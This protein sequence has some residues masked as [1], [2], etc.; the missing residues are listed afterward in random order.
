[1]SQT[2][3]SILNGTH[4]VLIVRLLGREGNWTLPS[5]LY[6]KV[7]SSTVSSGRLRHS[8][9][10]VG[11]LQV[12]FTVAL[13]RIPSSRQYENHGTG[14]D[15]AQSV[16]SAVCVRNAV[17]APGLVGEY[18]CFP[19]SSPHAHRWLGGSFKQGQAVHDWLLR[20]SS[21]SGSWQCRIAT[22][23]FGSLP[24]VVVNYSGP[25]GSF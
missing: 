12:R 18:S 1:M 3:D 11:P 23:V 17:G 10:E 4:S 14:A 22:I 2:I 25:M 9:R 16:E 19:S 21:S 5:L 13:S 24:A 6:S 7:L 8:S 15:T 20:L